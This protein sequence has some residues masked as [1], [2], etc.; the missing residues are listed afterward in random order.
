MPSAKTN[1]VASVK[2]EIQATE[3][4]IAKLEKAKALESKRE[5][6]LKYAVKD[7]ID[8]AML[9]YY[10]TEE[11]VN[12]YIQRNPSENKGAVHEVMVNGMVWKFPKGVYFQAP[13]SIV[14]MLREN[15]EIE[16]SAGEQFRADRD[17]ETLKALA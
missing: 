4:E 9:D 17:S 16:T 14:D 2:E 6:I 5:A 12:F 13:L 1:N 8:Q 15:Y 3:K 10:L 7:R 11:L